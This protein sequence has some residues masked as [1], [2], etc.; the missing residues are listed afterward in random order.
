MALP[1]V[2]WQCTAEA[3]GFGEDANLPV[4]AKLMLAE[5]FIPRLFRPHCRSPPRW[6]PYAD[7]TIAHARLPFLGDARRA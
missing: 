5:R 1:Q 6:H 4:L 2:P 7:E 3:R